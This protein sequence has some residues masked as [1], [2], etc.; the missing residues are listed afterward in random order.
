MRYSKDFATP[1]ACDTLVTVSHN[2]TEMVNVLY[3]SN[4]RSSA[5][6]DASEGTVE[7]RGALLTGA[8]AFS[9]DFKYSAGNDG[10]NL[11]R[12]LTR[13]LEVYKLADRA[14]YLMKAELSEKE[15]LTGREYAVE[16][17]SPVRTIRFSTHTDAPDGIF[18]HGSEFRWRPD[19]RIAYEIEIENKTSA[20]AIDYVMT[21]SLITPV[22][23][24]GLTGT[25]RQTKRNL[26][27]VGE[28]LWDLR[29]RESLARVALTWEN[30]TKTPEVASHKMRLGFS[31]GTLPQELV[32]L[33]QVQRSKE[34]LVTMNGKI[35]YSNDA[36]Q[37]VDMNAELTASN[38]V[39]RGDLNVTH[40]STGLE[41]REVTLIELNGSGRVQVSDVITYSRTAVEPR[42]LEHLFI[43]DPVDGKVLYSASSPAFTLRHQG[44][45]I[46]TGNQS[47]L[48][49][50]IQ[51]DDFSPRAAEL[52]F[53]HSL[54]YGRLTVNYDPEKL[55]VLL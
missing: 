25:I 47:K 12:S 46:K 7:V 55:Q 24:I 9:R 54:P 45:L 10:D 4:E 11:P 22:R 39:Y 42:A 40:P 23:D 43:F 36:R 17:S 14:K 18:K 16:L 3:K 28:L 2:S 26:R 48:T 37:H 32:L 53:D 1:T 8:I 49:Y 13:A 19:D 38:G 29:R 30:A 27:A 44:Q 21:T 20:A 51:Q 41:L 34:H 52:D 50:E 6:H 31:Q 33:A 35:Q 15:T 5:G